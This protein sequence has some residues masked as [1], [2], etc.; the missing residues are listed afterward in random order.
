L[1]FAWPPRPSSEV[2]W[3]L[4]SPS[5]SFI[6]HVWKTSIMWMAPRS[7]TSSNSNCTH[8]DHSCSG[9]WPLRW[10]SVGKDFLRKPRVSR[11]LQ[12]SLFKAKSFKW[13]YAFIT[14]KVQ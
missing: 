12:N 4:P 6:L 1:H 3:K 9:L 13:A 11:V 7:A 8:L 10:L 5:T 14:L 2:W